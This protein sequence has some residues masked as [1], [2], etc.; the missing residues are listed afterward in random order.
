M[1]SCCCSACAAPIDTADHFCRRCGVARRESGAAIDLETALVVQEPPI[2][3][4]LRTDLAPLVPAATRALG[5]LAAA[6][7]LDWALRKGARQV[8]EET[9]TL[10]G[11]SNKGHNG[12]HPQASA[13]DAAVV[14]EH[15]ITIR[16]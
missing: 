10:F 2:L 1:P 15:R 6:G 5:V 9:L 11:G 12:R 8:V 7:F 14:V 4:A 13:Q 16:R 3:P